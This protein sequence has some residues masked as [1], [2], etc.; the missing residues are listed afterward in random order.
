MESGDYLY[1]FWI[2]DI[3]GDYYLTDYVMFSVDGEEV[4]FYE[5]W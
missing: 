4:G 3:Y 2:D 5:E 1:A